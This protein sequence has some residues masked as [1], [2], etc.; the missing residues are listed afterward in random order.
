MEQ[1]FLEG[2]LTIGALY[3]HNTVRDSVQTL[4]DMMGNAT[5]VN[6]QDIFAHGAEAFVDYSPTPSVHLRLDYT[7]TH[8]ELDGT[9]RQE[10]LRRPKHQFAFAV[11]VD[12]TDELSLN[13]TITYVGNRTD[14]G[15]FGGILETDNYTL[16]NVAANYQVTDHL[17]I[18]ARADN[19]L[20]ETYQTADGFAG[21]GTQLFIGAKVRY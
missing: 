19:L 16:V 1:D 13:G 14:I 15:Y 6:N 5:T 9:Q 18:F 2:R 8:T 20:S 11:D 7:F 3:F 12:V 17:D 21:P 10:A 4:F